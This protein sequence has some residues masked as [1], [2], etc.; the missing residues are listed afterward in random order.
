MNSFIKMKSVVDNKPFRKVLKKIFRLAVY[1]FAFIGFVLVSGYVTVRFGLTNEKGVIDNQRANFLEAVTNTRTAPNSPDSSL[2]DWTSSEEWQILKQAIIQDSV[3]INK[4]ADAVK[5]EPRLIVA[6]L[7]P[8]QLRLFHDNREIFKQI[9]APLKI[10]GNQSQFSWGIMGMKQDTA[11]AIEE[12]LK[13]S[14]SPFYLGKKYENLLDF[15][16]EDIASERFARITDEENHYYGYLYAALYLKQIMKQWQNAG[17]DISD[18]PEILSTLYNIGFNNSHP[19]TNPH[20]GGAIIEIDGKSYSFGSLAAE[21]YYSNELR[22][23][24]P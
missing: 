23:Y 8:E 3:A 20:S 7:V 14:N 13:D 17:F 18:R 10:L 15:T 11:I 24:F 2:P 6:Q 1:C 21:F 9:F 4:V 16:S 19:N 5:I 12:H 22:D